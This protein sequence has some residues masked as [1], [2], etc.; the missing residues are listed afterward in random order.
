[1]RADGPAVGADVTGPLVVR[2]ITPEE[3][4]EWRRT[5][6]R[7]HYLGCGRFVGESVCY[8]AFL[9][10]TRVALLAWAAAALHNPPRD[11]Y[12][13]WDATTRARRLPWLVNN[14]RFLILPGPRHPTLASR[15]LAANL[16]R[17]SRDW[18]ARF[19]HPLL[20]AETFVDRTRQAVGR[21]AAR[22]ARA[23]GSTPRTSPAP[24]MMKHGA[25]A[26]RS[27]GSPE[28]I[29]RFRRLRL[30]QRRVTSSSALPAGSPLRISDTRPPGIP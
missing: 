5:M 23:T 17:L 20:P 6:A 4:G 3:R 13:G 18:Q 22:A 27:T 9:G 21:V 28:V 12:V 24:L 10:A 1:M 15:I 11:R 7:Y 25:I 19:G 14:V 2:P 16:R 8:A 30:R 26:A 29:R